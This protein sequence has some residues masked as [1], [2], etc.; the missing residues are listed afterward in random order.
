MKALKKKAFI[1][2]AGGH[3]RVI[4]SMLIHSKHYNEIEILDFSVP[5]EKEILGLKIKKINSNFEEQIDKKKSDYFLAIGDNNLRKLWWKKLKKIKASRPSLIHNSAV[6]ED[7]AII[8]EGNIICANTYLGVL[9][10]IGHN[11]II[12]SGSSIDH[13]TVIEN[14]CHIAP[15]TT[16]SGRVHIKNNCFIGLGSSI[17]DN[18]LVSENSILG[19]GSVLL[20][21][22]EKKQSLYVGIPAKFKKK[23]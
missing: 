3:C 10:K 8:G 6:I 22:I 23:I 20:E 15:G 13:E 18:V 2:G 21:N 19:A 9:T 14:N 7:S 4:A 12:N 16:I 11:N 5:L 17:K 1:L